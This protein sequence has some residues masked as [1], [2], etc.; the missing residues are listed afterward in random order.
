[1]PYNKQLRMK[2]GAVL[3]LLALAC[4][5]DFTDHTVVFSDLNTDQSQTLQVQRHTSGLTIRIKGKT[6]AE[7]ILE[8][9]IQDTLN[10]TVYKFPIGIGKI[11]I[12]YRNDWYH[13][14]CVVRY[15][16]KTITTG[17]IKVKLHFY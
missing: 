10:S 3:V 7:G 2:V 5:C 15:K 12:R 8:L 11:D 9:N 4:G 17:N 16:P 6:D 14:E 1:M 13:K